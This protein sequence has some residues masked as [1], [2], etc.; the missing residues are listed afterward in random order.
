MSEEAKKDTGPPKEE[1]PMQRLERLTK[2]LLQVP[3]SAVDEARKK[4]KPQPS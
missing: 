1:T 4:D 3:K 2:H